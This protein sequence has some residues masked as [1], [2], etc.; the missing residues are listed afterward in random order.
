MKKKI[1]KV[2]EFAAVIVGILV[3]VFVAKGIGVESMLRG[4]EEPVSL[5]MTESGMPEE[6]IGMPAGSD[7]PRIED[8]QTW[9]DTWATSY[10]TIEPESIISTGIGARYSW[11][12]AYTSGSRRGGPRKR[13]EVTKMALDIFG[14][15]GE[16]FLL[17]LPDHSYI[18]AQLPQDAAK[19]VK[20]G[21]E[22][23]LPIGRKTGVHR[24]ILA[25]IQDLC[26]KYDVDTEGVFYCINDD[27]NQSHS[28]MVQLIRIGI[29]LGVTIV[30][31]AILITIIDKVLK[32]KD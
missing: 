29:L 25:N 5:A 24:Q 28:M 2:L 27:W 31:G 30:F 21:K 6:I 14:E 32:V 15:Y 3:G 10:I 7:I 19:K 18:L 8:A 23:V 12:S 26:D 13:P 17:E 9:E 4:K 20:A 22:T 1:A 11:V 16:Y